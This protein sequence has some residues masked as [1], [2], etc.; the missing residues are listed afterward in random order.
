MRLARRHDER[1]STRTIPEEEGLPAS[2]KIR[3][4]TRTIR[5]THDPRRVFAGRWQDSHAATTRAIRHARPRRG[6]AGDV[7]FILFARRPMQRERFDTHDP[8]KGFAGRRQD[9][10]GATTRAI[11]H[12]RSPQRVSR[13]RELYT[14]RATPQRDS[15]RTIPAGFA[16]RRARSPQRDFTGELQKSHSAQRERFRHARSPQSV[17]RATARFARRHRETDSTRTIPARSS[18]GDVK[19]RTL[20][21]RE[22][23]DTHDPRR[24]LLAGELYNSHGTIPAEGSPASF[25]IRTP[26]QR[27]GDS[28]RTIPAEGSPASFKIRTAP[29][30]ERFAAHDPRRG[31][32]G[33]R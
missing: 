13:R 33:R 14:I 15:T 32:A 16:G 10:H 6:L 19:I 12:A 18:P 24:G 7:S 28:T 29:Q 3:T 8:R 11:R 5:D 1:D 2:F 26:P 23:F 25:K 20:P 21:Q 22:R 17:R 31:F 9:S 4:A 30:R 27:E